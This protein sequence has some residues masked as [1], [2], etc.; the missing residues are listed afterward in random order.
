MKNRNAQ[1]EKLLFTPSAIRIATLALMLGLGGACLR[2]QTSANLAGGYYYVETNRTLNQITGVLGTGAQTGFTTLSQT[3]NSFAYQGSDLL[4]GGLRVPRFGTIG[5]GNLLVVTGQATVASFPSLTITNNTYSGSGVFTPSN[6]FLRITGVSVIQ[7]FSGA[8]PVSLL[9]TGVTVIQPAFVFNGMTVALRNVI[10]NGPLAPF[11]SLNTNFLTANAITNF[12]IATNS[13]NDISTVTMSVTPAGMPPFAYQWMKN[14]TA[15]TGQTN[16]AMTISNASAADCGDF[17][18]RI[19]NPVFM[20]NTAPSTLLVQQPAAVSFSPA[21]VNATQG[22]SATMTAN[23]TGASP[24]NMQFFF[25][26]N[27]LVPP[28]PIAGATNSTFTV[29]NAQLGTHDGFFVVTVTNTMLVGFGTNVTPV[30]SFNSSANTGMGTLTIAPTVAGTTLPADLTTNLGTMAQFNGATVFNSGNMPATFQWFRNGVAIPGATSS[31]LS[32]GPLQPTDNGTFFLMASNAAGTATSRTAALNVSNVQAT[33]FFANLGQPASIRVVTNGMASFNVVANGNPA[34]GFQWQDVTTPT[35][36]VILTNN[37]RFAGVT[38][39]TMTLNGVT[40]NDHN[41]VFQ[42]VVTNSLGSLTSTSAT[43]SIVTAPN[44]TVNTL[45]SPGIPVVTNAN[46]MIF[47]QGT[48]ITNTVLPATGMAAPLGFQFAMNG[49]NTLP[50]ALV[51][52][53]TLVLTNLTTPQT[54]QIALLATN[55]AGSINVVSNNFGLNNFIIA[56]PPAI[57]Q[58]PTNFSVLAS[59][60][61]FVNLAVA[62]N[63]APPSFQMFTISNGVLTTPVASST[64]P[65]LM[66]SNVTPAAAGNFAVVVT[67]LSGSVTSWPFAMNV[68]T[69]PTITNVVV[70]PTNVVNVGESVQ[71]TANASPGNIQWFRISGGATNPVAGGTANALSMSNLGTNDSG[72]FMVIVSNGLGS[73]TNIVQVFVV[74]RFVE[75]VGGSAANGSITNTVRMNAQGNEKIVSFSLQV[76]TNFF[77]GAAVA[78]LP[79]ALSSNASVAATA[80]TNGATGFVITWTNTGAFP[81]GLTNLLQISS[82]VSMTAS[83]Q[84][85]GISFA[86]QPIVRGVFDAATNS[87]VTVWRDAQVNVP[88]TNGPFALSFNPNDANTSIFGFVIEQVHF[89]NPGPGAIPALRLLVQNVGADSSGNQIRVLNA[90][91]TTNGVPYLIYNWPVPAGG[92]AD[93]IIQY[94][95]P[96]QRTNS[97]I[98]RQLVF[99]RMNAAPFAAPV[100]TN[101][102]VTLPTVFGRQMPIVT[103]NVVY[104]YVKT[105]VGKTNFIQFA[106]AA[107]GPWDTSP[108]FLIGNGQY[109]TWI[110]AGPPAMSTVPAAAGFFRVMSQ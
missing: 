38:T 92:G 99:E 43:L 79:P 82:T 71:F 91:G 104:L 4:G 14:G 2:A 84:F 67:N 85:G 13:S 5:L 12:L 35:N 41:R 98:T 36:V 90:T 24:M 94:M 48:I 9:S 50:T 32:V 53:T 81:V 16:A 57:T 55:E 80:G 56:A 78:S 30:T 93:F 33:P 64:S 51:N 101:A 18:C 103:N 105:E 28:T 6:N 72:S 100:F 102:P 58:Q 45:F 59:S 65:L 95:V 83:Q 69:A 77:V 40:T 97:V 75:L 49:T 88:S 3:S 70:F 7:G 86:D 96:D 46:G 60:N 107:T 76:P 1:Q 61:A 42:V 8:T 74:D 52:P 37:V 19:S 68:H 110:G 106:P 26:T 22:G 47:P 23:A 87:L 17:M 11:P 44:A 54:N 25:T 29:T 31:S 27:A 89:S 73:A 10:T 34:V 21:N 108:V 62:D 39:P 109:Q 63:P 20:T 66:I 15:L